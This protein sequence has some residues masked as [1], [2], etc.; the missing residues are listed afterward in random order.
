MN[1]RSFRLSDYVAVNELL[2][3]ILSEA[4]YEETVEAFVRQLSLDSGLVMVA[5]QDELIVG[6]LI[7]TVDN[8]KGIFYRIAVHAEHQRR[9][10]G[11]TM[12]KAMKERFEQR[13]VSGIYVS[14]DVHNEPILA[15]YESAGY[16]VAESAKYVGKLA[17][18]SGS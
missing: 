16:R 12:I 13:R 10:I 4:C 3:N 9:G 6:V 1:V 8:N 11:R 7:G 18:V 2:E 15:V 5:E 14:V 17:I